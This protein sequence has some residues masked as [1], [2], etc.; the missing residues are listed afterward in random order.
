MYCLDLLREP[1]DRR[2]V[3]YCIVRALCRGD[4]FLRKRER[5]VCPQFSKKSAAGA[6][7]K[8]A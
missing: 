2:D 7:A 5:S 1:G 3:F 6:A 8:G 4:D